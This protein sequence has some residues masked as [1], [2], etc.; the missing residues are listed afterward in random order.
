MFAGE[1]VPKSQIPRKYKRKFGVNNLYR[2]RLSEGYRC[3]YTLENFP[4]IGV[5]PFILD[6]VDHDE[7]DEIFGYHTS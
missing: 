1:Q 6:L 2:Y 4:K 5:C 3:I 7:Y